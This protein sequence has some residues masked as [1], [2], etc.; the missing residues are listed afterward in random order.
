MTQPQKPNGLKTNLDWILFGAAFF[1][2][3]MLGQQLIGFILGLG[4]IVSASVLLKRD[5]NAEGRFKT[6]HLVCL[7][8]SSATL[9]FGV[10]AIFILI[11]VFGALFSGAGDFLQN[12]LFCIDTGCPAH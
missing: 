12:N 4:S 2:G 1:F 6:T 5:R 8:V 11:F 7:A 9:V 3:V 10:I